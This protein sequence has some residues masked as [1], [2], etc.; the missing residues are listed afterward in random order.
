M[1]PESLCRDMLEPYNIG[2][3]SVL[4]DDFNS[5]IT[6]RPSIVYH[7]LQLSINARTTILQ[8]L[9]KPFLLGFYRLHT[10]QWLQGIIHTSSI[11]R[12]SL[13][14]S[15]MISIQIKQLYK[16]IWIILRI[17]DADALFQRVRYFLLAPCC[18]VYVR[19]QGILGAFH[20]L[21]QW[22]L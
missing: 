1:T 16:V 15:S 6:N 8:N 14:T 20:H 4:S 13:N 9:N 22:L 7:P 18:G 2:F 12:H 21:Y 17:Q 5:T 3:A 19:F 10:L 11:N